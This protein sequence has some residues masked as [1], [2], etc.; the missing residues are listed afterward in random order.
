MVCMFM[1]DEIKMKLM[2]IAMAVSISSCTNVPQ[3]DKERA[4]EVAY[5][6][7]KNKFPRNEF[8]K[9][10]PQFSDVGNN[11]RIQFSSGM[12]VGGYPIVWIQ[13]NTCSVQKV[14]STQ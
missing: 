13:K 1:T 3:C 5:K 8:E 6:S 14:M 12:D 4:I 2:M 11:W 7:A 10:N 9:N